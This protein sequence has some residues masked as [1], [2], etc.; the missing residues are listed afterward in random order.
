M[1]NDYTKAGTRK[2]HFL[3]TPGFSLFG[4]SSMLG[5]LRHANYISA[6]P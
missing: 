5:P 1:S 6:F 2:I 3:L 4:L